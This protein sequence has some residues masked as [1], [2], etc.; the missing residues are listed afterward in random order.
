MGFSTGPDSRYTHWKQ[1]VFYLKDYITIKKGE[2]LAGDFN[3]S[4]N[5]RNTRDLDFEISI[6][7]DGELSTV[8]EKNKYVMH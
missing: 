5:T 1:T 6:N 7:F 2:T 3:V 4:P 8:A